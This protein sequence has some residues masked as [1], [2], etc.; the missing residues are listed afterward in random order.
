MHNGPET[1]ASLVLRLRDPRDEVAWSEFVQIYEPLIYN[2]VRRKG[3]HD[4]DAAELTQDVLLVVMRAVQRWEPDCQR[5][6]F[7][8]WLYTITRRLMIN[9]L[10]SPSRRFAGS[11]RTTVFE[12]LLEQPSGNEPESRIFDLEQKRRLFEWAADHV[13]VH[14]EPATWEAF[15]RTTILAEPMQ[16]VARDLGMPIGAV[17]VARSRV[18]QKLRVTIERHVRNDDL[19]EACD[20]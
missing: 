8:G 2:L 11:G 19:S 4:A 16:V 5:G 10:S 12:Y 7:R 17:Y 15:W 6:T 20:G 13:K 18:M 9:F 14:F 1:N 3:F